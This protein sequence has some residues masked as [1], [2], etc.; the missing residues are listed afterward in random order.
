MSAPPGGDTEPRAPSATTAPG[1]DVDALTTAPAEVPALV[2]LWSAREPERIGEVALLP[3]DC[4]LWLL[5]RAPD[6]ETTMDIKDPGLGDGVLP[7]AFEDTTGAQPVVFFRQ[8]PTGI[9]E[10]GPAR[11]LAGEAISRRQLAI[12]PRDD[13]LHVRNI[14]RCPLLINGHASH[15]ALVRPGDTLYLRNQ[16]LLYC[17]RRP[18]VVSSLRAYPLRRVCGYGQPDQDSMI[19]ESLEMWTL[20]ERLAACART[21]FH[22]LII[23]ESGSGKELAAQAIHNLSRRAGK[24]LI[25]DNIAAIPPSLAAALLFGNKKNFPNPGM[26]ERVGLIG[27]ADGSTLFLDEI[28]DMPEEV[29]PMFLRVAERNGEYFRLGE[30]GRIHR[31]DFRLVGATNRPE[32]MRY[33]LKRRFQ[34]EIRVPSLNERKEDI[35]LLVRHMLL[36]QAQRDDLDI[37]RFFD[38]G[39]PRV[40]PLLIEQLV[41]HTYATHV[42]EVAFLL[43]QAMGESYDGIICPLRGGPPSQVRSAATPQVALP[44]APRP[45]RPVAQPLPSVQ[46][47]QRA[48]DEHGG[49]VTQAARALGISRDQLNRMIQRDGLAVRRER[50]ARSAPPPDEP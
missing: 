39:Q 1:L 16:L 10:T 47:A 35:P 3:P 14:G 27:A 32:R 41:H 11:P 2:I 46:K 28:G 31:S 30:D 29:Q 26:E 24:K 15:S 23:G 6:H 21:N 13:V 49:Q 42:S 12:S 38:H 9:S 18:L 5:G 19:G 8:R 50:R 48:L 22:V 17:T 36:T 44:S 43:G 7:A 45:R 25:A 34:R 20:R 37:L 4:P 40:H 33:E